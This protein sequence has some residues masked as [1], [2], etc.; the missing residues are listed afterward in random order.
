MRRRLKP[1][2]EEG[3]GQKGRGVSKAKAE[4]ALSVAAL[5]GVFVRFLFGLV[6]PDLAPGGAR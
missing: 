3:R 5:A 6:C 1:S 2:W 4:V